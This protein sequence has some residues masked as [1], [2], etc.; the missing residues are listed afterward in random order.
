RTAAQWC[1]RCRRHL[2]CPEYRQSTPDGWRRQRSA[3]LA[4][5]PRPARVRGRQTPPPC[6]EPL[7]GFNKERIAN[8]TDLAV[9]RTAEERPISKRKRCHGAFEATRA[10]YP[11]GHRRERN[12]PSPVTLP[13]PAGARW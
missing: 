3:S 10:N 6:A 12:R 5:P 1:L 9:D 11:D 7:Q 2:D 13:A 4:P 8:T